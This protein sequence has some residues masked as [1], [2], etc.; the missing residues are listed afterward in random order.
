MTWLNSIDPALPYWLDCLPFLRQFDAGN[1]PDCT[2]LNALLPDGLISQGGHNI[3]FVESTELDEDAYEHRIYTTGQ[4]STR[5][6]NWHDLFNAM[7]WMQ[8]PRIKIAMNTLHYHAFYRQSEGKR[9]PLRDAL[10]LF[11]ECGVIVF[12]KRLDILRSLA[13]RDW[14]TAFRA[15]TFSDDVGLAVS[16]HAILEKYLSPYKS[17]TAKA[18]YVHVGDDFLKSPRKEQLAALDTKIASR[19][20]SAE[21]LTSP[22]C[23]APLPLAGIPGWWPGEQQDDSFYDDPMVFRAAPARLIPMSV[24]EL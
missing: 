5:A 6:D 20:L 4:V 1:F 7:I 12:S 16:G 11:D 9:G 22:A 10:T 3:R 2:Q 13:E 24:L 8:F 23:L 21:L 18:L 17:I 14:S 19:L 15:T